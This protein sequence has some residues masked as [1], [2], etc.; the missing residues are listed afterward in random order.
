MVVRAYNPDYSGGE[1]KRIAVQGPSGQKLDFISKTSQ[2]KPGEGTH[3]WSLLFRRRRREDGSL[4][5]AQAKLE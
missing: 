1:D 5:S 4:R 3:L 2:G